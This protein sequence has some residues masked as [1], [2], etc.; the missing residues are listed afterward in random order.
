MSD[1]LNNNW[2]VVIPE[3]HLYSKA[4]FWKFV[5]FY[6]I[7]SHNCVFCQTE[8]VSQ[9]LLDFLLKFFLDGVEYHVVPGLNLDLGEWDSS[10]SLG[11]YFTFFFFFLNH[12]VSRDEGY[13]R[14]FRKN[15]SLRQR[16]PAFYAF[17]IKRMP[18][19]I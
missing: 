5:H 19:L 14:R 15:F 16:L 17:T 9:C 10:S 3:D 1:V 2:P 7:T 18:I 6:L 11:P 12:T 13:H 4:P 8:S